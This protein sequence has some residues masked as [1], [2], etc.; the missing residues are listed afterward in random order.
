MS[1]GSFIGGVT[2]FEDN[3]AGPNWRPLRDI[4]GF[5]L[6]DWFMAMFDVRLDDGVVVHAYKHYE[7]RRYFHLAEDG[8]AFV[9]VSARSEEEGRYQEISRAEA[10]AI[11]FENWEQLGP[12]RGDADEQRLLL[13]TVTAIAESGTTVPWS[14]R[15]AEA[16]DEEHRLDRERRAAAGLS[17]DD[18]P[19]DGLSGEGL[20]A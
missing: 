18:D 5:K 2:F 20:A 4:V 10:I 12:P 9:F 15:D 8:R 6:A 7:T 1:I 13:A 16:R 11:A 14:K 19:F 17:D 3:G